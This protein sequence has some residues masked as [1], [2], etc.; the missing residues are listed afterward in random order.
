MLTVLSAALLRGMDTCR[1]RVLY[2]A[3]YF[4][5]LPA[6]GSFGPVL[7]FVCGTRFASPRLAAAASAH[8]ASAA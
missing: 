3:G 2:A 8:Y 6:V 4:T 7:R 5:G 1:R